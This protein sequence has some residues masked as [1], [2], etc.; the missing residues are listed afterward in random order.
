MRL[1]LLAVVLA[2]GVS[3]GGGGG[4]P[5]VPARVP[6]GSGSVQIDMSGFWRITNARII[7]TN[8]PTS[9]TPPVN[10]TFLEFASNGLISVEGEIIGRPLLE[11]DCGCSLS[12]YVNQAN[13][14]TFLFGFK[15]VDPGGSGAFFELAAAGGAINNDL[16]AVESFTRIRLSP[17]DPEVFARARYEIIRVV[18]GLSE[19]NIS[20]G[21]TADSSEIGSWRALSAVFGLKEVPL[22]KLRRSDTQPPPGG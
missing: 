18:F 1:V 4:G 17:E 11:A 20:A 19:G 3:C 13:G 5:S 7:E 12:Y 9:F 8:S 16:I 21:E 2:V 14:Q 10:G 15:A 6:P 22:T